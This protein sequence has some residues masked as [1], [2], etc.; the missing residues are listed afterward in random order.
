MWHWIWFA[1]GIFVGTVLGLVTTCVVVSG[2]DFDK[3]DDCN[4]F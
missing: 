2:K 4:E 1:A 3:H